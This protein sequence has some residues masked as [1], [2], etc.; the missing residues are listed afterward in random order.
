MGEVRRDDG[1]RNM[2][3][4]SARSRPAPTPVHNARRRLTL[5]KSARPSQI[6]AGRGSYPANAGLKHFIM[7]L[8]DPGRAWRIVAM[9]STFAGNLTLIGSVANLIVA[10]RAKKEGVTI[11]FLAYL[12][13]G[14]PSTLASLAFGIWWLA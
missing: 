4:R 2:F 8:P 7:N 11:S 1:K 12:R 3:W 13:I 9:S 5:A 14:L 10:E 6:W